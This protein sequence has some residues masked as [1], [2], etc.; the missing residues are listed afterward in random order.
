MATVSVADFALHVQDYLDQAVQG[1]NITIC[2]QNNRYVELTAK[3]AME[4]AKRHTKIE[5]LNQ[6]AYRGGSSDSGQIDELIY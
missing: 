6:I 3:T 5:L 4:P 1:E 2:L